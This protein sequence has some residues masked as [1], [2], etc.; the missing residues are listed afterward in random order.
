M[1]RR[2]GELM[3]K[4]LLWAGGGLLA[5]LA[6]VAAVLIVPRML[7]GG[8]KTHV[9]LA[10]E[11]PAGLDLAGRARLVQDT[12]V[13]VRE[14]LANALPNDVVRAGGGN[15]ILIVAD[16]P[17]DRVAL[18]SVLDMRGALGFHLV[19]ERVG[20]TDLPA[21]RAPIGERLLSSIDGQ[22]RMMVFNRVILNGS[23]I[24]DA[25][26]SYNPQSG[27]PVVDLRLDQ[28]GSNELAQITTANINKRLVLVL[29]GK[30][31]TAPYINTP[32]LGGELMLT[33]RLKVTEAEDLAALLRTVAAMSTGPLPAPAR[34]VAIAPEREN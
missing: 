6:V 14:R 34:I 23:H 12:L 4:I 8:P 21:D 17:V 28:T 19:D 9:V 27:E 16:G 15:R 30:V 18:Q 24:V 32:I 11:L 5:V 13:A 31:I 22:D 10:V 29:D 2:V 33:G 20:I 26:Q 25:R 1:R 3:A 7:H